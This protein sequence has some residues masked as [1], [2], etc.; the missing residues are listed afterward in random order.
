MIKSKIPL[1]EEISVTDGSHILY[2][3]SSP[4]QYVENLASFIQAGINLE[5]HVIVIDTLERI[6]QVQKRLGHLDPALLEPVEFIDNY[7]FYGLY[8]DFQFDRVL[9]NLKDIVM[10]YVDK[11]L[12]AR[13]WGH[14]EWREQQKILGKLHIYEHEVDATVS[15]LGYLTVC[16]YNGVEVPAYIQT[17]MLKS[18]EFF[19]TDTE[20]VRSNLYRSQTIQPTVFPSI[21][22]QRQLESEMDL[23]KQKLDF[24]HVVS[25]E[26]RN[27]L[28]IIKAYSSML[29][30]DEPNES[31]RQRMQAIY[32]YAVVIDNEISH[33][34]STEQMLSTESFWVKKMVLPAQLVAEVL[35]IME[36]KAR[37]QN[38]QL[39]H[40]VRL[41]G[42]ETILSNGMGFK[43]ILSNILN[44]AIKYSYENSTVTFA[45]WQEDGRIVME[46]A[47]QGIGMSEEQVSRLFH[48]Y[49]KMNDETTGQGIGLYMVKK[50]LTHFA[51]EISVSSRLNEGS[52]FRVSIPLFHE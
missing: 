7:E 4:D 3:Y 17:E 42:N 1:T 18:H 39:E 28:T 14:V 8:G 51:G 48:K 49:E 37:T 13:L 27:P 11:R 23:Y 34:I 46:V 36:I 47:D 19:M 16:A 12:T 26:V 45:C 44:N 24:V 9:G 15:D 52:K 40:D 6:S 50:L 20:L 31:R 29:Q 43:L 25:H 41:V 33:I 22:V 2:F 10:P 32:D 35:E 38:V 21:S 5:Q 30:S